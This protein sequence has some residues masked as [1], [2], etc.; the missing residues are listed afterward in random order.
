MIPTKIFFTRG[1][2][3]GDEKILSFENA[4][5]DAQI[6]CYNLV[7]VSSILPANCEEITVQEGIKLLSAGQIV[8]TVLSRKTI[9]N[10]ANNQAENMFASIGIAKPINETLYGYL[11]EFSGENESL[12]FVKTESCKLAKKL[13]FNSRDNGN[14]ECETREFTAYTMIES[15]SDKIYSTCV[16]AAVFIE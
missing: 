1:I 14:I 11:S 12:R 7:K 3:H 10:N 13:L 5:R 9:K 2:G 15:N 4:L 8:Y 6:S 16:A